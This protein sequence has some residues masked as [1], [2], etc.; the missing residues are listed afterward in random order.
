VPYYPPPATVST[1]QDAADHR[2][3]LVSTMLPANVVLSSEAIDATGEYRGTIGR[4]CLEGGSGSKTISSAGGAIVFQPTAVTFANAG[5]TIRVGIQDVN[6]SGDPDG[7]YDVYADLVGA[8]DS[9]T[10]N[11]LR[12]VPMETGTKTISHG[13]LV[14]IRVG[15]ESRA[16][17]DSV[18][19][20]SLISGVY[21]GMNFPY[22]H[23]NTA[24]RQTLSPFTVKFDDGTVG[25]IEEAPLLHN[26][27]VAAST[28]S[29]SSSTTPDEYA[30][31]FR[32][33][34]E[35]SLKAAGVKLSGVAATEDFEMIL[36]STPLGTPS[37]VQTIVGD[38]S[39]F[40]STGT[41]GWWWGTFEPSIP[42]E[43]NTDYAIAIRPT[44]ANAF[45]ISY[46][47]LTTGNE[48]LKRTGSFG[49]DIDLAA[50]TNQTGAFVVTQTYH[51]P[52]LSL[53]L[54]GFLG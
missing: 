44:T 19:V 46:Y 26:M 8:T 25:W 12:V 27:A 48:F 29:I 17:A 2:G 41:V 21:E 13:D 32:F 31:I 53:R 10:A 54:N 38:A 42:L 5:T 36:Y 20:G 40:G 1:I 51:L 18:G 43:A 7:T 14:C 30:A 37:A 49:E 33:P 52:V 16:G 35:T 34:F 45:N 11:A 23:F 9:I 50:R 15:M 47:D 4:M 24:K 28:A 22:S 3:F 6:S 39:Y